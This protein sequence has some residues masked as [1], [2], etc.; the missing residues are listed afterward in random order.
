MVWLHPIRGS[1]MPPLMTLRGGEALTL[2][3]AYSRGGQVHDG[4]ATRLD[5]WRTTGAKTHGRE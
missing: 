2:G 4:N 5:L 3:W 1:S